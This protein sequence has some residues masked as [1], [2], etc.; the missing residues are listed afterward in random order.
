MAMNY[1]YIKKQLLIPLFLVALF[2]LF[3]PLNKVFSQSESTFSKGNE[4]YK[5]KK[6]EQ[7]IQTYLSIYEKG[8]TSAAL[9]LNIGNCYYKLN[10]FGKSILWYERAKRL[11]PNDEDIDFN[12]EVT[13]LKIADKATRLPSIFLVNWG[14]NF[15]HIFSATAWGIVSLIVFLLFLI[16][17]SFFL[18]SK[19]VFNRAISFYLSAFVFFLFGV[20]LIAAYIQ[21]NSELS[22]HKLIV[23]QPSCNV[24]S[25]PD[26]NST[27]LFVIHEG[28]SVTKTDQV[29]EW[30]EVEIENNTKGWIKKIDAEVI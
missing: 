13:R 28:T 14:N 16:S 22:T 27:L 21:R 9:C 3:S 4:L 10:E 2:M 5:N 19:T 17:L 29:G 6:Y 23:M 1:L 30:I 7:A 11:A 20:S 12:L 18:F 8:E 25:S 24:K 15:L 26:E